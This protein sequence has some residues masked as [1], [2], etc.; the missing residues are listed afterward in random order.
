MFNSSS[1]KEDKDFAKVLT[2][3]NADVK[4][5]NDTIR[6]S[7]PGTEAGPVVKGDLLMA[8]NTV[9]ASQY[10][11]LIENSSD[12]EVVSVYNNSTSYGIPIYNV[13]IKNI[14]DEYAPTKTINIV[15]AEGYP[16]FIAKHQELLN[17]AIKFKGRAWIEYFSFKK[18]HLLLEDIKGANGTLIV[19]KDLDYGY[20]ITVHKSQGST[21]TNVFVNE[22]NLDRNNN[23]EERNKLKYVALSR[24]TN[25]AYV[26]SQKTIGTINLTDLSPVTSKLPELKR[27]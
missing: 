10:E 18:Q 2:W 13:G 12:Y 19:K 9:T 6:K 14:D 11:A 17:N 7:I 26:L 5:W 22:D 3:T 24:P 20:A 8:Y 1:Y 16:A 21:Y 4:Y 27:C 25:Q 15:R 23:T